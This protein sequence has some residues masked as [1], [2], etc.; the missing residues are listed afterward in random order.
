MWELENRSVC[1]NARVW[2]RNREWSGDNAV[3]LVAFTGDWVW[4]RGTEQREVGWGR[5]QV[6]HTELCGGAALL[7]LGLE[8]CW[9]GFEF[10]Q[11]GRRLGPST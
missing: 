4:A 6:W 5:G 7:V 8:G 3:L 1:R 10:P 2:C 9:T 11:G